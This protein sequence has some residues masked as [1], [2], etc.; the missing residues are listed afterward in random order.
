MA[1]LSMKPNDLNFGAPDLSSALT[2]MMGSTPTYAQTLGRYGVTPTVL[3]ESASS[4]G[5]G[6]PN[7][8]GGG[9]GG[10]GMGGMDIA[11]GVL[12]GLQTIA[13]I[14]GAF[15]ARKLA[16][17]QFNFTKDITETN[18]ANQIKSYNTTLSD[19]SRSRAAVEGQSAE[20]A[21]AYIDQN[22]MV[23]R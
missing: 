6:I 20:Q 8:G 17:K 13:N 16:K 2:G 9:L 23:R 15:E 1:G 11:N 19:R 18:L 12:G 7:M 14:W 3:G 22:K 4:L 10:S 21:Q 5:G